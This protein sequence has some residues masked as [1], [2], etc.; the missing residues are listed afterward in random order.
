MFAS[1]VGTNLKCV[2]RLSSLLEVALANKNTVN[3]PFLGL[4]HAVGVSLAIN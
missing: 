3:N 2:A 1:Y 4:G